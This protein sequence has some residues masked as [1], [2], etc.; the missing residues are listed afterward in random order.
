MGSYTTNCSSSSSAVTYSITASLGDTF[1]VANTSG[2]GVDCNIVTGGAVTGSSTVPGPT[3]VRTFTVVGS[4][5][6]LVQSY[7]SSRI[8]INITATAP[9]ASSSST[10][11]APVVQHFGKPSTGTCDAAQPA[12]LNWAGVPSGG[13]GNSWSQW[14]NGGTGGY[15]C[16]RTLIYSTSQAKWILG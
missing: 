11:P 4:G 3:G 15:V 10:L 6:M 7:S 9:P 13:W 8:T 1:T 2:G 16:H 14:M 5:T 12:G